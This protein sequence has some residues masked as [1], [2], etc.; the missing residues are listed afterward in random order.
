[1]T[2]Q[3]FSQRLSLVLATA[4]IYFIADYPV[5][6]TDFLQY[7]PYIGIK[8]FLP[9][10]LGLLFGPYGVLGAL[11]G[12]MTTASILHTPILEILLEWLCII[13]PGLGM[14]FFWHLWSAS[15]KIHFKSPVNYFRYLGL[16][17]ALYIVCGALSYL[18]VEGGAF[19]EI[20]ISH[21]SL[22]F[23]VGIPVNILFNGV[24][25]L[26][27]ILPPT[28][29][30]TPNTEQIKLPAD[31]TAI[32]SMFA[33]TNSYT[34][35]NAI[36]NERRQN[37]QSSLEEILQRIFKSRPTSDILLRLSDDGLFSVILE[38]DGP[39]VNPLILQEDED[40]IDQAGLLLFMHRILHVGY[41][42]FRGH[43]TVR[44]RL[45]N[46][47]SALLTSS[48]QSLEQFNEQLEEYVM[49]QKVGPKV[50][51][52]QLFGLQNCLEEL[53]IRIC[54]ASSNVKITINVTY[55]DTFS[56]RLT[57]IGKKYNPLLIGKEEDEMDIASLKVIKHRALRA[58][59]KYKYEENIVHIVI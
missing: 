14:W 32:S 7:G 38:Y 58:S 39:S 52:K 53:Y 56:V 34:R 1:M 16:L 17:T 57:Y 59:Y 24:L 43:N 13:L 23:L 46:G 35:K 25:C 49:S 4:C 8:N 9:V 26:I 47:L 6:L 2:R 55:D 21:I 29:S 54:R 11:I 28:N 51:R 5:Q 20:M 12:C 3:K 33:F 22:G 31:D 10:T 42:R 40:E 18:L 30:F 19:W 50:G 44:F 48:P 15:H 36:A 37:L 27:P 45:S 41:H